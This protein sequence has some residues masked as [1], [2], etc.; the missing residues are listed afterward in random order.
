MVPIYNT[1]VLSQ[2]KT[3]PLSINGGTRSR[4]YG[5]TY[6]TFLSCEYIYYS[7]SNVTSL[8]LAQVYTI[9]D[10]LRPFEA[11]FYCD[12]MGDDFVEPSG[13]IALRWAAWLSNQPGRQCLDNLR[14]IYLWGYGDE[15]KPTATV[16]T[17]G[18]FHSLVM[19]IK[20]TIV[21]VLA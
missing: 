5:W 16:F 10:R 15:R 3:L 6:S 17:S 8:A 19:N 12:F 11:P 18:V 1:N 14:I 4:V 2:R 21:A 20:P 9:S 7:I 13:Y